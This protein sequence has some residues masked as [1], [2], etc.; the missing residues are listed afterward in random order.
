MEEAERLCD[1]VAIMDHGKILA[2]G[3]VDALIDQHGGRSVVSGELEE[4]LPLGARSLGPA[5]HAPPMGDGPLGRSFSFDTEDALGEISKLAADGARFRSLDIH[6]PDLES[7][8]LAL[9]GRRL[10]DR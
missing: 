4:A 10:R 2:L 8:F 3:T 9:T 6:Q 5:P 7:V 1:R